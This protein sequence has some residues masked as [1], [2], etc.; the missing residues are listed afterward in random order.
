MVRGKWKISWEGKTRSYIAKKNWIKRK[1]NFGNCGV[2]NREKV[3]EKISR[4]NHGKKKPYGFGKKNWRVRKE[5][6]GKS[7]VK[8]P[9][10]SSLN[11][12]MAIRIN[13]VNNNFI[14]WR[15]YKT[16]KEKSEIYKKA[17][18]TRKILRE[19][20]KYKKLRKLSKL[21]RKNKAK[22]TSISIKNRKKKLGG[23]KWGMYGKHHT[24]KSNFKNK[25]SV[26]EYKKN[27]RKK[28]Y[29]DSLK[30]AKNCRKIMKRNYKTSIEKKVEDIISKLELPYKFVGNGG[31]WIE[32]MN[33][34]FINVNGDKRVIE[35]LGSYWHNKIET[36][37]RIRNLKRYG[38]N[39]LPIWDYELNNEQFV[40]EKIIKFEKEGK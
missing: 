18:K 17:N 25:K 11:K 7:G 19:N 23:F 29:E 34:D 5:K 13:G 30:G 38:F 4:G 22:K 40:I 20:N 27:N 28:A 6:Y 33:P 32:N 31:V 16:E 15:N 21:E 9:I 12:S 26:L 14:N 3:S 8:N 39:C 35:V 10:L 2:K 37:K 1:E 36:N 24:K